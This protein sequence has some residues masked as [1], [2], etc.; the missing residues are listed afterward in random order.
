MKDEIEEV[1]QGRKRKAVA[2][3]LDEIPVCRE[4]DTMLAESENAQ[5]GEGIVTEEDRTGEVE[6]GV[7]A[8]F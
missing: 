2:I 5:S 8:H 4:C 6:K 7:E 1:C 3:E